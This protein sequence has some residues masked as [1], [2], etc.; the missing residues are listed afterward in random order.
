VQLNTGAIGL[1]R[2]RL[3]WPFR[4]RRVGR[5]PTAVPHRWHDE[6]SSHRLRAFFREHVRGLPPL[7]SRPESRS[8]HDDA[9]HGVGPPSSRHQP[10]VSTRCAELP[11]STLRSVLGVPPAL[12]GL[13]HHRPCG[14]VSPHS[15]VQG[16]PFRGFPFQR[17][18]T[19][20]PW[21]RALVPLNAPRLWFDPGQQDMP[22]TSRLCSPRK[23]GN[24]SER[25]D[26]LTS[27][28][29]LGFSPSPGVPPTRR[30]DAFTPLPSMAFPVM[31]PPRLTCDVSPT[32]RLACLEP[33]CRPAQG[34][35]LEP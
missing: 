20:F 9:S 22:P 13:L 10:A 11:G 12:D 26:S 6:F 30:Q 19:R 5:S 2:N 16:S 4:T 15:R 28:A 34:F 31:N 35:R 27:R 14:F 7:A 23:S 25:L 1:P 21:P 17:S 29:P 32:H 3:S 18:R 33:G 8:A 24:V